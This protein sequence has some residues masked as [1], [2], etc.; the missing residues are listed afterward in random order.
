MGV[1]FKRYKTR[2]RYALKPLF[3]MLVA[4][5]RVLSRDEWIGLVKSTS[6]AV[7]NNPLEFLGT[8]LPDVD[9]L[10]DVLDDLFHEFMKER[11]FHASSA[12]KQT[13]IKIFR[14]R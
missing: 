14:N 5:Q 12:E 10:R 4:R 6:N 9:L 3:A 8:D 13:F 2:F 7:Q 1:L 11:A